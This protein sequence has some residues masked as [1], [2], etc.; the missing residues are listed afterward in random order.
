MED[1]GVGKGEIGGG[2]ADVNDAPCEGGEL[3][4]G[5]HG[6]RRAGRIDDDVSEI[7]VGE[8]FEVGEVGAVGFG[9]D[10]VGDTEV[11]GAEIEA[12]LDHI[13]DDDIDSYHEFEEFEAGEADGTGT[14]DQHCFA[15]LR[16][17]ALHGMVADGEGLDEGELIVGEVVARVELA[18][19]DDEGSLAQAAIVVD[20][21]YLH[22]RAAVRVTFLRGGGCGIVKIRFERAFVAGLDVGDAFA[23]G[24]DFEPEF[25]AGG[26][27][28]GEER[29]FSE[30]A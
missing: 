25:M 1:G 6:A 12:A 22:A 2:D 21:D 26:A 28:V 9:E 4:A 13:H 29:K 11:F 16:V 10:T 3:E 24:Y 8:F 5:G 23:D 18:G 27:R 14:D 30:V 20:A 15:G 7:S 19:G 17:A